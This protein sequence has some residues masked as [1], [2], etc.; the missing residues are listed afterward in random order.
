MSDARILLVFLLIPVLMAL[1]WIVAEH[2]APHILLAIAIVGAMVLLV[3]WMAM[4]LR[5]GAGLP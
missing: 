5:T 4:E 3:V 2:V 1:R